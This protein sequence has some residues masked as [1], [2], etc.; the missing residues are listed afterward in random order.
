M[1]A[2]TLH[3]L[4]RDQYSIAIYEEDKIVECVQIH[5]NFVLIWTKLGSDMVRTSCVQFLEV[6]DT[7]QG[8]LPTIFSIHQAL[9]CTTKTIAA[10]G[11]FTF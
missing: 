11:A 4:T 2:Y 8:G 5:F 3:A 9:L 7:L 10:F 6:R 1:A